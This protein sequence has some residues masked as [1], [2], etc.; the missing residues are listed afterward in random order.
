MRYAIAFAAVA[1]LLSPASALVLDD[2]KYEVRL[3]VDG[4]S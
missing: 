3:V 2:E 1:A 4:L